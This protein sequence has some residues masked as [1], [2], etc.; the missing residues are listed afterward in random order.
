MICFFIDVSV[1]T[2]IIRCRLWNMNLT[3][4]QHNWV[5]NWL[6]YTVLTLILVT[7]WIASVNYQSVYFL[8]V[9]HLIILLLLMV[10]L[11]LI[12]FEAVLHVFIVFFPNLRRS[13]LD[14]QGYLMLIFIIIGIDV[15]EQLLIVVLKLNRRNSVWQF[16]QLQKRVRGNY[17]WNTMLLM[18]QIHIAQYH[19]LIWDC[20]S[21]L[22]ILRRW[23]HLSINFLRGFL[24][25]YM[26][27]LRV[28]TTEPARKGA[29]RCVLGIDGITFR[30]NLSST[31]NH[32]R[33]L[34]LVLYLFLYWHLV[35]CLSK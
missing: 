26:T 22:D 33:V 30:S 15:A 8:N 4:C 12:I 35:I 5:S 10:I 29:K 1:L 18:I 31:N 19:R 27:L 16:F 32:V 14:T 3:C 9:L 11:L 28:I 34:W 20:G 23:F 13:L 24:R 21:A 25:Y 17:I 2:Q 6:L 7:A